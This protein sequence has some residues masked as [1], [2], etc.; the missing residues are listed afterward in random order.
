MDPKAH[1]IGLLLFQ[2]SYIH[3]I[4][5]QICGWLILPEIETGCVPIIATLVTVNTFNSSWVFS[6]GKVFPGHLC[7]PSFF[8][9]LAIS[10]QKLKQWGLIRNYLG[11]QLN[12]NVQ[13]QE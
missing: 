7:Q 12:R 9:K 6:F 3:E 4:G 8:R 10:L 1:T 5:T 11:V 2:V 13:E